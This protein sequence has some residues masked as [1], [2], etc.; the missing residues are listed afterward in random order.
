METNHGCWWNHPSHHT[1]AHDEGL[2]SDETNWIQAVDWAYTIQTFAAWTYHWTRMKHIGHRIKDCTEMHP[3][4]LLARPPTPKKSSSVREAHRTGRGSLSPWS[5]WLPPGS[6]WW[7]LTTVNIF[8]VCML[9]S[10]SN[11]PTLARPCGSQK[12]IFVISLAFQ[13]FVVWW[14]CTF[15]HNGFTNHSRYWWIFHT[16]RHPQAS[17]LLSTGTAPSKIAWKQFLTLPP[18]LPPGPCVSVRQRCHQKWLFLESNHFFLDTPWVL[19]RMKRW[20][21]I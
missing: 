21:V 13:I 7:W 3:L 17:R 14:W 6:Y 16:V 1:G 9:L 4:L 2:F 15:D 5:L 12:L 10:P 18:S 19:S 20:S 11:Q 8:S